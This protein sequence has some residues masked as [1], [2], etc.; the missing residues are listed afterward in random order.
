MRI[1]TDEY[2][3]L[4]VIIWTGLIM[5]NIREAELFGGWLMVELSDW[6][7][8]ARVEWNV[9]SEGYMLVF[10]VSDLEANTL[11]GVLSLTQ[12]KVIDFKWIREIH[13]SLKGALMHSRENTVW[14]FQMH[15]ILIPHFLFF[16]R[17]L[18]RG[19]FF[20][21]WSESLVFNN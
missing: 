1:L 4:F 2:V 6:W 8:D 13:I 15:L 21:S 20:T 10:E 14:I 16:W 17:L 9:I 3:I 11:S 18:M 5:S 12:I 19:D 7:D